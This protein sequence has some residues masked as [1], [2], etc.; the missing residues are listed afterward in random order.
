MT[1][2]SFSRG[3]NAFKRAGLIAFDHPKVITIRDREGLEVLASGQG[4]PGRRRLPQ[5]AAF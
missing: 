1:L 4:E 5:A 3:L 2:T